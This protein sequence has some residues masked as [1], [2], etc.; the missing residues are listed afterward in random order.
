MKKEVK[1]G[2]K[3]FNELLL[4][5][6]PRYILGLVLISSSFASAY[7]ISKSSDRMI[8]VWGASVDLAPGESIQASDLEVI[9]VRLPENAS[10]YLDARTELI[11]A[12]VLRA[13]GKDELI[14]SYALSDQPDLS[15]AR[16]PISIP[17]EWAPSELSTG[18]T[19]DLY[20]IPNR[21]NQFSEGAI[22]GISIDSVDDSTRELG[23]RIGLTLLVPQTEVNTLISAFSKYE[24]LLVMQP[25]SR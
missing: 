12:T 5:F 1:K 16:V 15:L 25:T 14:P 24:F 19:V 8:T 23:G 6:S 13:I 21:T 17:R 2:S 3:R 11:G 4:Y 10:Q 20:G 22:P 7:L 18:M 9:S